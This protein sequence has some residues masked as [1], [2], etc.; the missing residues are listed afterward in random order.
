MDARELR[1]H[2]ADEGAIRFENVEALWRV[3]AY[4]DQPLF[5]HHGAAVGRA[6]P[7]LIGDVCPVGHRLVSCG[8][9]AGGH[10]SGRAGVVMRRGLSWLRMGES[11]C[12]KG[13]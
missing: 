12:G 8:T 1:G 2:G 3:G 9:G 6:Q 7:Q 11:G 10:S 5:I 4:V 13:G